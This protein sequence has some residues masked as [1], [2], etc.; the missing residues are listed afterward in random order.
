MENYNPKRTGPDFLLYD[1]IHARK[2]QDASSAQVFDIAPLCEK[3]KQAGY[4]DRIKEQREYY[5]IFNSKLTEGNEDY[6]IAYSNY[7][8][9]CQKSH[10]TFGQ[11]YADLVLLDE[12]FAFKFLSA[13]F[14]YL[15]KVEDVFCINVK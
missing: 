12:D 11:M 3:L 14:D 2:P 5:A 1:Y 15:Q 13:F 8:S 9:C 6:R 10:I 7:D 4:G